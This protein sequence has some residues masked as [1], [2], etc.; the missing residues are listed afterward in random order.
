MA[1][2]LRYAPARSRWRRLAAAAVAVA[3]F[4]GAA[5]IASAES[6]SW[7]VVDGDTLDLAGVRIR[8]F[9]IDAPEYGQSCGPVDCGAAALDTLADILSAGTVSCDPVS[10]DRYGRTLARC[11][12]GSL[13]VNREM[14]R[15]S[16]AWAF[17][18]Y[19]SD[20]IADEQAA[21]SSGAG[22][23]QHP[24][25][26]A[27]EYRDEKWAKAAKD[28]PDGCAI[29]GNISAN[30]KIYHPPWSPWYDRTRISTK[31]G[32]RWFCSEDEAIAAG[33]RAPV[34]R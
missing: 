26:P 24:S 32:E 5:G 33:W 23:W 28:A 31:N 2:D 8:L 3:A 6:S 7:R 27:W 25:Q 14:V 15:R 22:I 21:K 12:A 18:R 9:G 20:Y 29:K 30:G 34:W 11:R 17:V 10:I 13:D 4:T 19:S 1:V 16:M